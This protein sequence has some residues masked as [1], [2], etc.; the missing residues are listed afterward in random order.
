MPAKTR[1]DAISDEPL[2][3]LRGMTGTA[4]RAV[5]GMGI[6]TVKDLFFYF[7]FRYDVFARVGNIND[8]KEGVDVIVALQLVDVKPVRSFRR[9]ARMVE[10]VFSDGQDEI[11]VIWFNQ[12]YLVNTL[13][14]GETYMLAGKAKKTKYGLR[15]VSPLYEKCDAA[16]GFL[17]EHMP[18]YPLVT[19]VSQHVIRRLMRAH[20]DGMA[21]ID[22]P[23][24]GHI[25]K[26]FGLSD[27]NSAIEEVHFPSGAEALEKARHRV[28]FDEIL[29]LQLAVGRTRMLREGGSAEKVVFDEGYVR[30]FVQGLPFELTQDQRKAAWDI[31]QDMGKTTPMHRLLDGDVGSG[32]TVVAAIA[33][34]NV[35][36][37]GW[38]CAVM[39]PTEILAKQH[40]ETFSRL[41]AEHD[42]TIGLWTNS[43]KKSVLRGVV[44]EPAKKSEKEVMLREIGEG[45]V[46]IVIGTHALIQDSLTFDRLALAI[47]DEQ[48][49]FGVKARQTL[50][51]KAGLGDK[52][53]HLLSMT[54]TPI[55]RSLALTVF[56][57]LDISLLKTKPAERI[58]VETK[59]VR[60]GRHAST[61]A[62]VKKE[63]DA[64]RQVFVV[65]PLIDP[66]DKLGARSVSEEYER[67]S[68][69]V[70]PDNTVS[71]LHGKM[72]ADEKEE[73]MR[74][75]AEG[76]TDV[77]VS[78][79]VVEVGVDVPNASVMCIIGAERFGLAQLHQFRG[80]VGR[81]THASYCMLM[82][83]SL[84]DGAVDRLSSVV[85][86]ADG[87][88]LA[89]KDLEIRGPGNMLGTE[90][91]G[92][93]EL[94]VASLSDIELVRDAKDAA[95]SILHEDPDL[96]SHPGLRRFMTS[97]LGEFHLE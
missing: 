22:D 77:L 3:G 51:K 69:D 82:P 16:G 24:P 76:E 93:P 6:E 34:A 43:F 4:M 61:Y 73:T 46:Q 79:S 74:A 52:E 97:G 78:T 33:A 81:G 26:R 56:G 70:F 29:R 90:Q 72:K 71:A 63:L 54:A 23:L 5:R 57:D 80:R 2:K 64:G 37:D 68:T 40:F 60:P 30:S 48:H 59:L 45:G 50:C 14:S 84:A 44:V 88:T 47:I 9:R 58:A 7:P 86:H 31:L 39:A 15:L 18:V 36:R 85:S 13:E 49:R 42:V 19:G 75:F 95:A 92:F 35:V 66:S 67:L 55:P 89:E 96:T 12:P 53:P 10:V 41:F 21:S 25:R 8:I 32:K 17:K 62:F 28:G 94:R 27:L 65:C 87:F 38:Q 1:A 20:R 83:S 11:G 91:T